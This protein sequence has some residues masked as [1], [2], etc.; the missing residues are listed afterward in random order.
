ME[1][2]PLM[3]DDSK[4]DES[5]VIAVNNFANIQ[6]GSRN[7]P[8]RVPLKETSEERNYYETPLPLDEENEDEDEEEYF[9]ETERKL[10]SK[11]IILAQQESAEVPLYPRNFERRF[12]N[13]QELVVPPRL[14][15][16]QHSAP[17]NFDNESMQF[18]TPK[19]DVV[20]HESHKD[21]AVS[22]SEHVNFEHFKSTKNNEEENKSPS[23]YEK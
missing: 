15:L 8:P 9:H 3:Q 6:R 23:V 10:I 2:I 11:Q 16:K 14:S 19:V 7:R 1:K 13:T 12:E 20:N 18:Q 4:N 17:I 22:Y 5:L 21:E